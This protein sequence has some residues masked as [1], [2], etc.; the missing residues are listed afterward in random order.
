MTSIKRTKSALSLFPKAWLWFWQIEEIFFIFQRVPG[1]AGWFLKRRLQKLLVFLIYNLETRSGPRARAQR[2]RKSHAAAAARKTDGFICIQDPVRVFVYI[3]NLFMCADADQ[4]IWSDSY[5]EDWKA[6]LSDFT[7]HNWDKR[8]GLTQKIWNSVENKQTA[9]RQSRIQMIRTRKK[10][11]LT[12]NSFR[13]PIGSN[14]FRMVIYEI[15]SASQRASLTLFT[16]V[17]TKLKRHE[18]KTFGLYICAELRNL[19]DKRALN[20]PP[21]CQIKTVRRASTSRLYQ[22]LH[23]CG[24]IILILARYGSITWDPSMHTRTLICFADSIIMP[25]RRF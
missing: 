10:I 13:I 15:V 17:R 2:M 21:K 22:Q 20:A 14:F 11:H 19:S 1:S 3:Y 4:L 5:W 23:T 18:N 9:A 24:V 6:R 12:N 7:A 8:C 25:D 16:S